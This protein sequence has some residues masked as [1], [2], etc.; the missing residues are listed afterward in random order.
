M[1]GTFEQLES[2]RMFAVSAFLSGTTIYV[3]GDGADNSISVVREGANV[4]V[5]TQYDWGFGPIM[6]TLLSVP[7]SSVSRIVARGGAGRDNIS[8]SSAITKRAELYGDTGRDVITGGSGSNYIH[9]GADNDI[10]YGGNNAAAFDEI[11]GGDGD[12]RLEGREG[13]DALYGEGG[14]DTLVGGN[15]WDYLRGGAGNDYLDMRGDTIGI[16]SGY[17]DDGYDTAVCDWTWVIGGSSPGYQPVDRVSADTE[18]L[19]RPAF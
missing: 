14:N 2:R 4:A 10:L 3:N 7:D 16:D 11:Y 1:S 13:G 9:G 15:G 17:G 8:V 19:V 6:A 18:V 12:D 5:R